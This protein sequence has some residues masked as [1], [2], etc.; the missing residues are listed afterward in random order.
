MN[1]FL[2]LSE[3]NEITNYDLIQS[4]GLRGVIIKASEGVTFTDSTLD[5]KYNGLKDKTN[6]GYYH[7]LTVSSAPD[8]QA[9]H[10]YNLTKDKVMNIM[11]IL[12]VE[13]DKLSSKAE[14]FADIFMSRY[15]ELSGKEMIIYS[16][17][18]YI[19]DNFSALFCNN[20]NFWVADYS[21]E[22]IISKCRKIVAWQY[23]EDSNDY[24]FVSGSVDCNIL[25]DED[26]F[27]IVESELEIPYSD[28][29]QLNDYENIKTLQKE[30]NEQGCTDSQW[31]ELEVDGLAGQ[32]TLQACPTLA[33]GA[34]GNITKWVQ[35]E[36]EI[37]ADGIF[38]ED[39]RQ[40]VI[41]FQAS[42]SLC[43]DGIVGKK[44]WSKLLGMVG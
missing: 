32:K 14:E 12:D 36:L 4:S 8:L 37:T 24:N 15:F 16:G 23:T 31:N 17:R 26:S 7:Y 13:Q 2:D 1:K 10:F 25:Y 19:E 39:T 28:D 6:I 9:E 42:R 38:G 30:L 22:P 41:E 35:N 21:S 43:G 5:T 20:N 18:C 11:P 34:N 3:H 40:A 33:I 29:T 27:F 44:T